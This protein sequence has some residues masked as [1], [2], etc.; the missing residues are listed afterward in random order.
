[1]NE[2]KV[3]V[4][5]RDGPLKGRVVEAHK[6]CIY[7]ELTSPFNPKKHLYRVDVNGDEIVEATYERSI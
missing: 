1:M 2:P 7:M 4:A 6:G 3:L 5:L